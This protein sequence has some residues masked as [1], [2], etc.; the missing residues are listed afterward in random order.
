MV[1]SDLFGVIH[2]FVSMSGVTLQGGMAPQQLCVQ[3]A[4]IGDQY[5]LQV[6]VQTSKIQNQSNNELLDWMYIYSDFTN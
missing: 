5:H 1:T 6:K 2:C 4:G 3:R